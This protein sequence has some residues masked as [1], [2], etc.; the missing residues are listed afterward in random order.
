VKLLLAVILCGAA[1]FA[2][3]VELVLHRHEGRRLFVELQSLRDLSQDL[4][5]E[6]G[7]LLLEQA[8][9]ATHVRVEQVAREKLSMIPADRGRSAELR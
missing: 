4:E 8:T 6:W 7:Q 3:A 5:Q 2:S 9:W 1:A